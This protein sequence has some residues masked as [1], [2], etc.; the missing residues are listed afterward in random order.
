[1]KEDDEWK[2]IEILFLKVLF[3]RS[4]DMC[5]SLCVALDQTLLKCTWDCQCNLCKLAMLP[6]KAACVTPTVLSQY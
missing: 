4:F 3:W 1:M 6:Q 2:S 5:S